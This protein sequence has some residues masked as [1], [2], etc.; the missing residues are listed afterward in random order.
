M[1]KFMGK[2]RSPSARAP[3][4]DYASDGAYFITICTANRECIFGDIIKHEMVYSEIGLIVKNEWEKSFEI[5]KELFCNSWV[6]MPNHLHA[7][8]IIDSD[9]VG[10]H[11]IVGTHGRASL[12]QPQQNDKPQSGV[13]HRSPHSISSFVA[14]F[15]SSATKRIN[16]FRK[17]PKKP[18]WQS[19]FHDH[20]IRNESEHNRIDQYILS[21]PQNWNGDKFFDKL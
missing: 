7:I 6:M 20:I 19:R 16:E 2:Y 1:E 9:L 17:T 8:L 12:P 3:W 18:V 14:G 21:N 10:T 5:R 15:K 4:W 13:A 11:G